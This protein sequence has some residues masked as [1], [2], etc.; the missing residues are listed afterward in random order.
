MI[1]CKY[2]VEFFSPFLFFSYIFAGDY[3]VGVFPAYL[4]VWVAII[5]LRYVGKFPVARA[6]FI[7]LTVLFFLLF[8]YIFKAVIFPSNYNYWIIYS[9]LFVNV[10]PL[11]DI[12]LRCR[13]SMAKFGMCLIFFVCSGVGLILF[14]EG[15]VN[16]VFGPNILYRIFGV[17]CCFFLLKDYVAIKN[18]LKI[19]PLK[20]FII[21]NI[22]SF[23][24]FSTGSRGGTIVVFFVISLFLLLNMKWRNMFLVFPLLFCF[25]S[26]IYLNWTVVQSFLGRSVYFDL[27]NASESVRIDLF[28]NM[29]SFLNRSSFVEL[30]FGVGHPNRFYPIEGLY[31][32]NLLIEIFVYHGIYLFIFFL[33]FSF[34]FFYYATVS[35]YFRVMFIL[36]LPIFIGSLLSGQLV[37]HSYLVTL[38]IVMTC[39]GFFLPNIK[40][41]KCL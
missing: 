24:I 23:S 41:K 2:I 31:P 3:M 39:Y 38:P 26:W 30:L 37:D 33:L 27:G 34:I 13:R 25:F 22:L 17:V 12:I 16:F 7:I 40:N 5:F 8:P 14:T 32:H 35:F 10:V 18:E 21:V 1:I 4:I 9:I 15:N 6:E 20:S 11:V 28:Y 36:F 29:I 19:F